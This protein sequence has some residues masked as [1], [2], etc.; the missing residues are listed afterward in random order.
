M[1]K[2]KNELDYYSLGSLLSHNGTYNFL[3]GARGLGKTFSSKKRAISNYLKNNEQFIYLRRYESELKVAKHTLFTDLVDEFPGYEFRANG[4]ALLIRQ[5]PEDMQQK[6]KW[7]I[8]GYAIAL[9][10]AQQKKSVSYH[11]VTLIVFD[12]FI[13]ERGAVRYLPSEAKLFNDFYSTVDRYQDKTK[14]LFLANSISIMNPYFLEYDIKPSPNKEWVKKYNGFIVAHFPT[15]EA[16]ANSVYKTKFGQFIKGTEYADYA[17]GSV[18]TDTTKGRTNL[19]NEAGTNARRKS[20]SR[21][22]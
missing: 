2:L 22:F 14:V 4:D 13:I 7:D 15:A 17:V 5:K 6:V 19:G 1:P 20:A 9:S 3:V 16:F 11:N 21:L 18:F 10:K 8:C 12:E